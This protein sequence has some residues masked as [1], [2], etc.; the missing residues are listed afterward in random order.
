MAPLL[1][2][3]L[4][5]FSA[6]FVIVDPLGLVPVFVAITP[7][8]SPEFRRSMALRACL[9]AWG[10]L[11]VFS[12]G[13]PA[14]LDLFGVTLSAFKVAG[15]LLMLLTA[16]DMLR[17]QP[18][19]TRTTPEE[20][21]EGAARKDVSVVPL[22]M[23]LLAGPGSIATSMMCMVQAQGVPQRAGVVAAI[24]LTLVVAYGMLV[25]ADR[26]AAVLGTS[27]R[28]IAE[29]LIGL[30]LAAISVQFVLDGV[31]DVLRL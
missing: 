11:V 29:R 18:P 3:F 19:P 21:R 17:A 31:R 2:S 24:T 1:Q 7:G 4:L 12:L 15:G 10:I 30:L 14:V 20:V 23:P 27:G 9:I 8:D 5:S 25:V 16:M 28:L 22:A 6:I 13:G 26:V